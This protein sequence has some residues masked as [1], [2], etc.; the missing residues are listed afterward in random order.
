ME[1]QVKTRKTWLLSLFSLT[2]FHFFYVQ[3]KNITVERA[4]NYRKMCKYNAIKK[5]IALQQ[6]SFH[7]WYINVSLPGYQK[8]FEKETTETVDSLEVGYDYGSVMHYGE[9]FFT[10]EDGLRTL[11]P[12][13]TT[14]ET[15][16]QR[17]GLSDLDVQQGNLLYRCPSMSG[18]F[19]L[20][21]S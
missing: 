19:T 18:R 17:V 3:K 12:T 15:I 20:K 2:L 10:K 6:N 8:N 9:F 4:I 21:L 13:Q 1:N 16:G 14:T 7:W 11:E 5:C